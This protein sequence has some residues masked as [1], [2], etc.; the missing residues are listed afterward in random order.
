[1]LLTSAPRFTRQGTP[2]PVQPDFSNLQRVW[3]TIAPSGVESS[4]Y[5]ATMSTSAPACPEYTAGGWAVDA[6]AELPTLGATNVSS[7]MP[8]GVPTGSITVTGEVSASEPTGKG[9]TS[10]SEGASGTA[11]GLSEGETSTSTSTGAAAAVSSPLHVRQKG[12]WHA[13]GALIA[14]GVAGAGFVLL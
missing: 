14:L 4:A 5:A 3:S 1:M 13:V 9:T 10:L 6:N 11:S 8:D 12:F 7:G 2:T